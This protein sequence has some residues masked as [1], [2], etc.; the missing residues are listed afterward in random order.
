MLEGLKDQNTGGDTSDT[1]HSF[2]GVGLDSCVIPTRHP[3][4]NIV[5]TTDFFYPLVDD[6]YVQG[7]IACANV[8]SD[9][10]ATGIWQCDNMLMLLG[11]S[12]DLSSTERQIVTKLV[13]RGFCDLAKEAGTEINGGQTVLNPWFI[14]GGVATSVASQDEVIMPDGAKE[15]DVIVLTKP[16]G[17]QIA[18]NAHLWLDNPEK[19]CKVKDVVSREQV[20]VAYNAAMASMAHLNKNAAMLMHKYNAH[21]ATDITGFGILGHANNL[22]ASQQ[23]DVSFVIEKLPV[24]ANMTAA[25]KACGVN[26]KLLAGFSAETS[27]GLF[28]CLPAEHS[29]NFCTELEQL[30]KRP[31]WIIGKVV[32]GNKTAVIIKNVEVLEV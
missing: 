8:L 14:I 13:I 3:G 31:S 11:I 24:L 12:T 9:L 6:P 26:F 22:A 7:K 30:D 10:Y 28:V 19:W 20:E 27:G 21:A 32:V 18:V 15:G 16:L 2:L 23:D 4:I 25:F 1:S 5:Q 29:Q 17:T